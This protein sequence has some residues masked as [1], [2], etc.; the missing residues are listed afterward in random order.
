MFLWRPER[1]SKTAQGG[2]MLCN[3]PTLKSQFAEQWL[4][5]SDCAS[6]SLATAVRD[7]T[8]SRRAH[9][10]RAVPNDDTWNRRHI[11]TSLAGVRDDRLLPAS[12]RRRSSVDAIVITVD[13]QVVCH[14]DVSASTELTWLEESDTPTRREKERKSGRG[15]FLTEMCNGMVLRMSPW[16]RQ[17]GI[18]L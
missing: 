17:H 15:D 6:T 5:A 1:V 7:V 11:K 3:L 13:Y 12:R 8:L 4:R 16:M 18:L 10:Q 9:R 14:R 2:R